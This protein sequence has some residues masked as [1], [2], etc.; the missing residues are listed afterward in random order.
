MILNEIKK[1]GTIDFPIE[2]YKVDKTKTYYEMICHFHESLEI[3]RVVKGILTINLNENTYKLKENEVVFINS[4]VVHSAIPDNCI[5][6]C[7]V[8][9]T[10][11]L[12][13]Q[14][15]TIK[16]FIENLLNHNIVI[17]EKIENKEVISLIN[18]LISALE[19]NDS[20]KVIGLLYLLYSEIIKNNLYHKIINFKNSLDLNIERIKKSIEYIYTNYDKNISLKDIANESNLSSKYFNKV[21]KDYTNKTP[22][23]FLLIHRI[24]VSKY[25]LTNSNK[26]IS[27]IA[28][29]SGFNDMSYFIKTFKKISNISPLKYR[30][31]NIK[32]I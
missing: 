21:F 12:L 11:M 3:V 1:H 28:Y 8:F 25:L 20:F 26:T 29:D 30:K 10:S 13:N 27:E 32:T 18:N 7:I 5:Y 31:L 23:E 22:I 14:N 17:D 24:E 15:G 9:D 2:L 19:I 16:S 6:D 4:S